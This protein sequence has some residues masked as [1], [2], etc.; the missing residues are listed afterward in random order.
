[1]ASSDDIT[2]ALRA[3]NRSDPDAFDR[4]FPLVVQDLRRTAQVYMD[5]E[6][7]DHTL[8]ATEVVN[9]VCIKLM[10]WRKVSWTNRAEFFAFAGKLM[11]RLLIDHVRHHSSL[12]RGGDVE[13]IPL[14]GS[15]GQKAPQSLD[16]ELLI[17]L[18]RALEKFQALDPQAARIVELRYFAGMTQREVAEALEISRATVQRDWTMASRWL[19]LEL[20][21]D[22]QDG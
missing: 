9:E 7:P 5:R 15:L 21:S 20:G 2:A 17:D 11:R 6:R 19:K 16:R 4:L 12:K 10:G 13:V 3:W 8:Q 18:D 1:M 22:E 14:T